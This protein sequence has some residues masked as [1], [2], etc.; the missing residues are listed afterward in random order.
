MPINNDQMIQLAS[1]F[2]ETLGKL[3]AKERAE[4]VT[5]RYANELNKLI[6]MAKVVRPDI[7]EVV[8]PEK[9]DTFENEMGVEVTPGTYAEVETAARQILG[10][11]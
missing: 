5:A 9:F 1:G 2:V 4:R 11:L 10:L 6:A 3:T 7:D 8:W